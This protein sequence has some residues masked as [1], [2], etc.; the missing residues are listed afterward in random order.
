MANPT[1]RIAVLG[2]TGMLGNAMTRFFGA[3]PGFET[4]AITRSMDAS[5]LFASDLD[6]EFVGGVDAADPD[7]LISAIAQIRPDVLINC[8]GLVKQ[9]ASAGEVLS[10]VPIN[11]LLPHR[12]AQLCKASGTRL[13]HVSTDCVYSGSKG[14]YVEADPPDASDVYGLSKY[15][16]EVAEPHTVTLR[17]SIIGHE[18]RTAHSLLEWFLSQEGRVKGYTAAVF[19]GVP[20]VEL[21]RIIRDHVLDRPELSGLYHV[22]AEPI[23]KYDLLTLIA[24]EYGKRIEIIPDDA[25]KIDRSLNSDRFRQQTGYQ[26]PA[27]RDLIAGMRRF[28]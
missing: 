15:L 9:L 6:V 22:S 25:L 4:I 20:T 28:G 12:L 13:V 1:P 7:S 17:T 11:S 5:R 23:A 2:A 21:A 27:W 3:D 26:P 14:G 18:L 19:S 10:A 8:I 16:G 24:A